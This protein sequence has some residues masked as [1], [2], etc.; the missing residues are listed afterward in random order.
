[1]TIAGVAVRQQFEPTELE[2]KTEAM[3]LWS[4]TRFTMTHCTPRRQA[5]GTSRRSNLSALTV[6][7]ENTRMLPSETRDASTPHW[8][9]SRAIYIPA[10]RSAQCSAASIKIPF[11]QSDGGG[12]YAVRVCYVDA[13]LKGFRQ[14]AHCH[15]SASFSSESTPAGRIAVKTISFDGELCSRSPNANVSRRPPASSNSGSRETLFPPDETRLPK[16]IMF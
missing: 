11:V 15:H 3:R 8:F 6:L 1:M 5:D 2:N 16:H 12:S 9:F 7:P 13:V 14:P 10:L 4:V